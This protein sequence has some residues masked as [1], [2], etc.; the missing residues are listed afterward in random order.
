[1]E[2][3]Q[4]QDMKTAKAAMNIIDFFCIRPFGRWTINDL[5]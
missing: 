1:M 4:R 5:S 3:R 2:Y